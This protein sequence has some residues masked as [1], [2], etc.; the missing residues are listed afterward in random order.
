MAR[1]KKSVEI[2]EE[3]K[4]PEVETEVEINEEVK[5]PEVEQKTQEIHK[6]TPKQK[7]VKTKVTS[8]ADFLY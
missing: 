5:E 1:N 4:E 6:T 7:I 3:V 2:N 8:L